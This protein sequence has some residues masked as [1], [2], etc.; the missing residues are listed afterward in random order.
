VSAILSLFR[1]RLLRPVFLALGI[2][3]LVQVL[4]A[5][6]LTRRT[7]SALEADLGRQLGADSTRLSDELNQA[8]QD[9][10][11]SLDKLSA[12]TRQR[13]SA[14]LS[15]RLADEQKQV[16]AALEQ[17]LKDSANDMAELLASVA[18]RAMWDSDIP[19]LSEFARRAQRNPN[20]LFVI[21]DDATG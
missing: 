21:Y 13:L 6:A 11:G 15:S 14:G 18:P 17:S 16:R 3:L 1:S 9:L 5:V 8:G 4:V 10:A 20:V 19:A 2:A 7:V 12:S